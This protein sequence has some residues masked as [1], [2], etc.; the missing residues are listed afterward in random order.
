MHSDKRSHSLKLPMVAVGVVVTVV[1]VTVV[2]LTLGKSPQ[3][4]GQTTPPV[5][6][7]AEHPP[8]PPSGSSDGDY[9]GNDMDVLGR[10]FRIPVA[11]HG[12]V[13][14]QSSP[15]SSNTALFTAPEGLEW[16]QVYQVPMPFTT[17]AGPSRVDDLGVPSGFAR[18][19]QGAAIA[20]L[21]IF[22]RG[23]FGDPATRAAIVRTSTTGGTDEMRD[24]I[25]NSSSP[26]LA[27]GQ[28]IPAAVQ[29]L[30]DRYTENT[31]MVSWAFGP[32]P[33]PTHRPTNSGV[34]YTV[35]DLPMVWEDGGWKWRLTAA[36]L[37]SEAENPIP[38][39]DSP[40]WAKWF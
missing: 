38:S 26:G 39:V 23:A 6:A 37:D 15:S 30:P 34:Y 10:G 7:P 4:A 25:H 17:D 1:A 9:L 32:F 3:E 14:P 36:I 12:H 27:P 8:A 13:L 19:R 29:I 31:A 16:Q 22:L 24:K 18:T 28:T 2:A 33:S 5:S 21:Q 11:P 35:L 40:G 20:S